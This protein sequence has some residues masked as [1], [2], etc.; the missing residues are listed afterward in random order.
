VKLQKELRIVVIARYRLIGCAIGALLEDK[1]DIRVAAIATN[2]K[3][4][5]KKIGS[6]SPNM[7]L[8][9]EDALKYQQ[10]LP[11]GLSRISPGIPL[12]ILVDEPVHGGSWQTLRDGTVSLVLKSASKAEL[13]QAINAVNKGD[14]YISRE[15][16]GHIMD[17]LAENK[18]AAMR[19]RE[20][21]S[22]QRE[23]L[24]LLAQGYATKEIA[25]RLNLS[26]RTV[27]SHRGR[28]MER[29]GVH[30]L[31]GL[32]QYAIWTGITSS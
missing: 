19:V 2:A 4:V 32:V 24:G 30:H 3:E 16:A 14:R 9:D 13:Y 31:A 12:I 28:I 10:G 26:P 23:I 1:R 11:D 8:I 15:L 21:T 22:R 5:A 25:D 27:E 6:K 20:L 29:L 17:F 7:F 18:G